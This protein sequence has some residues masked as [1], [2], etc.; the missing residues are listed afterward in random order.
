LT[1]GIGAL[2][3]TA[4]RLGRAARRRKPDARRLPHLYFLTDPARTPDPARVMLRL[5]R[6]AAVI[7]RAFG[8]VD[9]LDE[10]RAL[11]ALARAR[12][13]V[14]LVGADARLAARLQADGVHLPERLM[15]LAPALRRRRPR[16][17]IT[18][19]AHGARA[20][21]QAARLGLDAV[22]V[23][24]VF[25]SRSQSAGRAMG[26]L[27]FA[28][29]ARAARLPVIALGGVDARTARRLLGSGAH[30]LAAIGGFA[31]R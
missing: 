14:F 8:R 1:E 15:R 3:E 24:V 12:G 22:L 23:S 2:E 6:G 5:P 21:A 16:W 20:T 26:P 10:A 13:L 27:R 30:G 25:A 19:A 18:A 9:L 29:R 11:R 17:L 4:A 7:Y 31:E 28:A